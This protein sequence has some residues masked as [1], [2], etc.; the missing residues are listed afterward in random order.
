MA[1]KFPIPPGYLHEPIWMGN[2]FQIG[3]ETIPVLQYTACDLGWNSDL[4]TFH[5][6]EADQGNHYI[7]RASRLHAC[8]ELKK[9]LS[10]S[11]VVLEIGSSSGYLLRDIK[12]GF[13]EIFLIGS[14]CIPESLEKIAKYHPDIPLIQ[15]DLVNCPLPDNS[16]DVIIALNVLEHIEDDI[17]ALQ[18]IHRILKPGGN[19]IIEVPANPELYDFYDKQLKHFRRYS[20]SELSDKAEKAGFTL[21]PASHLGFY[22]YPVFWFIKQY[23]KK[24]LIQTDM[25]AQASVKHLIHF[26]GPIMN[27]ILYFMMGIELHLGKV[28]QYPWGIRCLITLRKTEKRVEVKWL[29]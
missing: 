12:K 22:V 24:K 9:K 14:D 29:Q 18:Q 15:F 4:T 7:D 19:V 20:L 27:K 3:S 1:F 28:I 13:P 23:S 8:W 11:S 16:V 21:G 10:A 6:A 25:E 2:G 26:G 5:E 17:T